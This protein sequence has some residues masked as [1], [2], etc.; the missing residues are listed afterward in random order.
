M[1]TFLKR[2]LT[3]LLIGV[4]GV[5]AAYTAAVYTPYVGLNP[6]TGQV[7][8]PAIT[9]NTGVIPTLDTTNTSC[10]TTAT[11]QASAVGGAATFQV[12]ANA[13]TCTLSVDFQTQSPNGYFCVFVDE[14]HPA[15]AISQASHTTSSCTSSSATV[16][17]G[18]K[19]LVEV[20]GF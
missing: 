17:S 14:T 6:V 7:G 9:V 16:T 18:D 3:G 5:A 20:N 1:K 11:V 15:D 12:T 19:I 8:Q 13:T 10:G 4:C 2:F